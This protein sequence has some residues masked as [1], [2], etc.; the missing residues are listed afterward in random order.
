MQ[1][2]TFIKPGVLEWHEVPDPKIEAASDA[3]VRPVAVTT[4]DIDGPTIRG[5]TP[6]AMMGSFAFGHEFV[7]EIVELG[8]QVTGFSRGQLVAV[9]FQICCG[10]CDRCRAGLSGSC[11][12]VPPRSMFG[13]PLPLG[14]TWGGALSD[15]VR[16]PFATN[17]LVPLPHGVSAH[18]VASASDNLPDAWRTVGPH[19]RESPGAEVLIVAGMGNSIA[20][21]AVAIARALGASRVDF[22]DTDSARLELAQSLGARP[23]EGPPPDRAGEYQITVDASADAA[24]LACTL[25]SLAPGG[26]CTSIGIYYNSPI[27]MPLLDMYGRGVRFHTGRANA[28]AD[29][30][31]V[32]ELVQAGRIKPELVTSEVVPWTHAAEALS[33]P[34]MKPL[35]V[36]DEQVS[37]PA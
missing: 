12:A 2:L 19:L 27:P 26:V 14:G 13:F 23:I 32:L 10:T 9:S 7:A 11:R 20:L 16:V 3:L 6:L 17:M 36:R 34:S 29:M 37:Q 1:Q 35:I 22:L 18:A 8:G 4:C 31:A 30:P 5:L 25:R 21:Y 15:L 28:R 24:G 33:D